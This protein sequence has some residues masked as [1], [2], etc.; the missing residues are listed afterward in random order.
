[1]ECNSDR[2]SVREREPRLQRALNGDDEA[3]GRLFASYMPQLYRAA[4]GLLGTPQ[5][6]EDALQDGLVAALRHLRD[7]EGRSRFSTWLT[8]IVINAALMRLRRS[9]ADIMRSIDEKPSQDG[10]FLVNNIADPRPNPEEVYALEERRRML[11]R[12]LQAL[13]CTYRSALWMRDVEGMNTREA[14]GAL[15]LTVANLKSQLRRARLRLS[16][17]VGTGGGMHRTPHFGRFANP[18]SPVGI[19]QL[20][21]TAIHHEEKSW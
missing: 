17:E 6:A 7:F 5:D 19:R 18:A 13:P 9:R 8:Q 1:M 11:K 3:L 20:S 21:E 4:L 12:R 15:G 16:K 2:H 10:A 14:A